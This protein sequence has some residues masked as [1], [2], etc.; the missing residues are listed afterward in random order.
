MVNKFN[1]VTPFYSGIFPSLIPFGC[2]LFSPLFGA[3]YDKYGKGTLLMI[4]G[5]LAITVVHVVFGL[6]GVH[7]IWIAVA[8]LLLLGLGYAMLPAALW[9][10][11][12]KIMPQKQYGTSIALAFFIQNIGLMLV[13]MAIGWVLDKFC[14][15]STFSGGT[16]SYPDNIKYDYT[17]PQ[18]IFAAMGVV[19]IILAFALRRLDRKR[20]YGLDEGKKK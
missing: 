2:I 10:S 4:I 17:L 7:S 14:L 6:P 3:V 18:I 11:L 8:L 5:A 12:A 15:L 19:A 16:V 13:P 9:P 20:H 1:D